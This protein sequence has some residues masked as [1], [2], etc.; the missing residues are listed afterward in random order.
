NPSADQLQIIWGAKEVLYK[1][2]EI[3][4]VDFKKHLLVNNFTA[5]NSGNLTAEILKSGYEK[6]YNVYF[7][8]LPPMMISWASD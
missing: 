3:G 2:H 1:I 7:E 4:D 8:K 6:K 5:S